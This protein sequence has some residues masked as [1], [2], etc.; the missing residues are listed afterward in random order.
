MTRE[1]LKEIANIFKELE[2]YESIL[3]DLDNHSFGFGTMYI[4]LDN[5]LRPISEKFIKSKIL[6]LENKLK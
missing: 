5:F 4:E 2:D 1:E 3:K 6:E